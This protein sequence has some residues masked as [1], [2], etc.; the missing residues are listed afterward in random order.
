MTLRY[1][2]AN[3]MLNTALDGF[4]VLV[5]HENNALD[6]QLAGLRERLLVARKARSLGEFLRNQLDLLPDTGARLKRD[7]SMRRALL[8]G[9]TRDLRRSV[10]LDR[11]A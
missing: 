5:E 4:S 7:H 9:L 6:N 1:I 3:H 10:N 8:R 11:A 2:K